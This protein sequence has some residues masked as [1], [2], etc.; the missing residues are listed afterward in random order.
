MESNGLKSLKLN[1]DIFFKTQFCLLF[2]KHIRKNPQKLP[3]ID[4]YRS[5]KNIGT[6][7]RQASPKP[8]SRN[9]CGIIGAAISTGITLPFFFFLWFS[10]ASRDGLRKSS[11]LG[12]IVLK[13][14]FFALMEVGHCCGFVIK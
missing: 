12:G 4:S 14:F 3:T 13:F 1:I 10:Y 6:L 7:E 2:L 11:V 8:S 5:R 9:L